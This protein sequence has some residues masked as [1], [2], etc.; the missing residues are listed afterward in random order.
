MRNASEQVHRP[1][2]AGDDDDALPHRL[3]VVGA[4]RDVPEDLLARI[5]PLIF[6]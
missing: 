1:G 4:R 2:P 6:T 5:I 3:G